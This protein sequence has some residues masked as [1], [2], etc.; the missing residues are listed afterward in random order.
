MFIV[1][2]SNIVNASNHTKYILLNNQKCEIQPTLVILHPNEYGQEFHCYPFSVKLARCVGSYNTINDLSNKVCIPNKT[3][4]QIQI[5]LSI[6]SMITGIN[7]SK[8]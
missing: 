3:K 7:E 1:V 6:F 4:N 5:N 2:L 8:T